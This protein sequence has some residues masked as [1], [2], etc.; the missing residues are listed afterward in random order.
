MSAYSVRRC[1]A[2]VLAASGLPASEYHGAV[3][4]GNLPLPGATVTATQGETKLV[5]TTDERGAFHF[6]E[7]ADG[8]W[9]IEVGMLG[10]DKIS[11]EVGVSAGAP[12]PEWQLKFLSESALLGALGETAPVPAQQQQRPAF[13]R[14]AVNQSSDTAAASTEGA[15]KTEEIA[16]LTQ[17]AANSFI[18][19]GSMSSA[20]GLAQQNDWGPRGMDG[21]PGGPGGPGMGGDGPPGGGRGGPG[22]DGPSGGRGGPGG[23]GP[24]PGGGMM[25]GGDGWWWS[26]RRWTGWPR[27]W[28]RRPWRTRRARWRARRSGLDGRAQRHG[29][30]QRAPRPAQHVHG[31]R[32]LQPRQLGAGMRAAFSVT[33]AN[34]AKPA[35][36]N[37]RGGVMFG[38]PLRIP[39]L[40][41]ADK[42]IMFS[43]DYQFQRNR[44]GTISNPVN[45]PTALERS[46]DFSQTLCRAR[47]D[48]LRPHHGRAVP[49]QP[50]SGQPHQH[51]RDRAAEVFPES[52]SSVRGAQLPDH[53][54]A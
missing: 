14:V 15:I 52:Q 4:A 33:G 42:H 49:R 27:R 11:H 50:D 36:A 38:G 41:S 40:V 23:G 39:K 43:F 16:D 46:G 28:T 37:G 26:R 22:G 21:G 54:T 12:A 2:L 5:T 53:L 24:P 7:L 29:V 32:R 13:R 48:H 51:H 17:S 30:R 19:Q 9:I 8:V 34:V 35:Y 6:A 31:Q 44:T 1:F 45:M 20:A 10:F 47:R 3:K 18:V 25:G